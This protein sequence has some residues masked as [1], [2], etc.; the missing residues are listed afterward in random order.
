MLERN[1]TRMEYE[2]DVFIRFKRQVLYKS[3]EV[4]FASTHMLYINMQ[5]LE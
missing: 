4:E 3:C 5:F 2:N 1:N